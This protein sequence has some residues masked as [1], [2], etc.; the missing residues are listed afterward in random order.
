[1][2]EMGRAICTVLCSLIITMRDSHLRS[3]SRSQW[4]R[5]GSGV[6]VLIWLHIQI[7]WGV[8]TRPAFRRALEFWSRSWRWTGHQLLGL[9]WEEPVFPAAIGVNLI[10]AV[11][12]LSRVGLF[13]TPWTV[14]HQVPL[15]S[16][17]H[18]ISQ[19]R[20][21]EWVDISFSRGS[22]PH[23]DWT[24]ISCINRQ[25]LYCW[26]TR[27]APRSQRGCFNLTELQL[28]KQ[29]KNNMKGKQC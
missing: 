17:V 16:S 26:A 18:G 6:V 1:M 24:H 11:Q 9:M 21:M 23:R 8:W 14:A 25:I 20:I 27:E 22:F 19:A 29:P 4:H 2:G 15:F 10:V 7:T 13:A 12:S 28:Q 3:G 5:Q